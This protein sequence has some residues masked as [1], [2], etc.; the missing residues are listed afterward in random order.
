MPVSALGH[1]PEKE[2]DKS[3]LYVRPRD[4]HPHWVTSPLLYG[5]ARWS[6]GLIA[7]VKS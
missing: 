2:P 4:I 7:G 6:K 1:S 5:Y 3:G